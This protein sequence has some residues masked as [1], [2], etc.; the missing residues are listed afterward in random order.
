MAVCMYNV[1]K[2]GLDETD[3]CMYACVVRTNMYLGLGSW[4][5][6]LYLFS[7]ILKFILSPKIKANFAA[8]FNIMTYL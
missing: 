4:N 2:Y 3:L 5:C 8:C 6:R 7:N 1:C